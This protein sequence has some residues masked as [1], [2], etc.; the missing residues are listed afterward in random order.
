MAITGAAEE[1][2]L[3]WQK[4]TCDVDVDTDRHTCVLEYIIRKGNDA[5]VSYYS[6]VTDITPGAELDF[7]QVLDDALAQHITP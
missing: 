3:K 2:A 1:L 4:L 7:V 6:F 5:E